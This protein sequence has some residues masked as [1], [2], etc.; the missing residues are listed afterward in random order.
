MA[1]VFKRCNGSMI[2]AAR[3]ER[4]SVVGQ[5]VQGMLVAV[6]RRCPRGHFEHS[7]GPRMSQRALCMPAW[8]P[9]YVGDRLVPL[10]ICRPPCCL[11][12]VGY[13]GRRAGEGGASGRG[14]ICEVRN[15]PKRLQRSIDFMWCCA[16]LAYC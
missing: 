9:A 10:T 7:M 3:G 11:R 14:T 15:I 8:Q 4:V 5:V 13:A 12:I 16:H 6:V 1:G 2:E